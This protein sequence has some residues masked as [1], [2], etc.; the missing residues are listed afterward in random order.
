MAP[1]AFFRDIFYPTSNFFLYL[2]LFWGTRPAAS[3]TVPATLLAFASPA[4]TLAAAAGTA[5]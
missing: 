2:R 1:P 4:I 3:P 5:I